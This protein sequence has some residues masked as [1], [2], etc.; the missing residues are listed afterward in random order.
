[1]RLALVVALALALFGCP[2]QIGDSCSLSSD[3]SIN[4]DR[5]CDLA[6]PSGYCTVPGCE[7]NGCPSEAMCVS[8][9][10]H[11]PRLRRRFC[12]KGCNGN[13]DCREGY[14]CVVPDPEACLQSPAI[15]PTG[16]SCNRVAD[17]APAYA[18]WCVRA[19]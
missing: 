15:L 14:R 16:Q 1:M 12:M 18:G 19:Q 7:A 10:A 17:T 13:D 6:Q 3:C 9:D 4:A 8:F 2:K 11:A 5:V